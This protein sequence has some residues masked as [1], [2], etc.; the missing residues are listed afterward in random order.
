MTDCVHDRE[1]NHNLVPEGH[2][3]DEMG[4]EMCAL[5]ALQKKKPPILR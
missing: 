4:R 3:G 2:P 5:L 1:C